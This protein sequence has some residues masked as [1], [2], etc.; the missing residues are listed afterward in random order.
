M[1]GRSRARGGGRGASSGTWSSSGATS[2]VTLAAVF[3]LGLVLDLLLAGRRVGRVRDGGRRRLDRRLDHGLLAAAGRAGAARARRAGA[4][5]LPPAARAVL[6]AALAGPAA[7]HRAEPLA[8][9]VAVASGFTRSAEALGDAAAAARRVLVAEA[10]LLGGR[11]AVALGHDLAL[12][13]PD[14]DADASGRGPSLH[15]AVVDVGADRVQRHAALGVL[16]RA[17][18]LRA[19]EAARALH[20]HACGATADGRRERALH[21]APERDAVLQLLGD[22]LGDELRVQLGALDLVDVDVHV[23]LG[24]A[25]HFFAERVDLDAG[26]ADDDAGPR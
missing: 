24:H 5:A 14:L 13:D 11:A 23:L 17:A 3:E 2:A 7:A 6:A 20:L 12:V 22:R 25:V 1:S 19:A 16:L 15:E 10:R 18:H 9:L 8:I 21:G 4:V 26:L